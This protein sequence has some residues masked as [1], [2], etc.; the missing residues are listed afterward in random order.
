MAHLASSKICVVAA[1]ILDDRGMGGYRDLVVISSLFFTF[2][3][4]ILALTN[5]SVVIPS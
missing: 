2:V 3:Y 5:M 1:A 4:L